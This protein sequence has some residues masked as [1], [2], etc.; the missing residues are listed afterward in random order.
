MSQAD[1]VQIFFVMLHIPIVGFDESLRVRFLGA[2][3]QNAFGVRAIDER[4][5]VGGFVMPLDEGRQFRDFEYSKYRLHE[6]RRLRRKP[7]AA[8]NSCPS[9]MTLLARLTCSTTTP[10]GV[11]VEPEV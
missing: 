10:F 8:P 5:H 4:I 6:P 2:P 7:G 11:P 1:F 3:T 9:V